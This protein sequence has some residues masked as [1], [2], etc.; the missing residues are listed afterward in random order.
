MSV[1]V[2][3][4]PSPT[5]NIHI[6]NAR[7]A[8][9]NWLF[10]QKHNG[11]FVQRFDD[12][13]VER[14]RQEYADAI[15]YDLHWL[16]IFPDTTDY[17]S[18]RF[19]IYDEAVEDA[20]GGWRSVSL[21][22]DAGRAGVEAQDSPDAAAAAVYGREALKLTKEEIAELESAGRRPHWRFCFRTS[23]VTRRKPAA[24]R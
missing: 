18:R 4:A 20:Q 24:P 23:K 9:F 2:R 21:L 7:T 3:F 10:A 8:L 11:R 12:T 13:D 17:Q 14:S 1:T 15:L 16:G 5:G 22:R 6:G 19:P